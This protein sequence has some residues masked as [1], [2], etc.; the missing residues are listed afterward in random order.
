MSLADDIYQYA[1]T[2]EAIR[3]L[4][5]QRL[6]PEMAR[7]GTDTPYAV[8][9]FPQEER[10]VALS[11]ESTGVVR[12]LLQVDCWAPSQSLAD[13]V[14]T[15]MREGLHNQRGEIGGSFVLGMYEVGTATQ[16]EPP[17]DGSD[18]AIYGARVTFQV[19]SEEN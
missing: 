17:D 13:S 5:G 3:G 8:Y 15:A 16:L 18:A 2:H 6:Y 11:L 1:I 14:A 9:S 19:W 12:K 4:I 10:I 7:Q